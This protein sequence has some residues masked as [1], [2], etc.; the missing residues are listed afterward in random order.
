MLQISYFFW[1]TQC[2]W[3]TPW[4]KNKNSKIQASVTAGLPLTFSH[5]H[6]LF[7]WTVRTSSCCLFT[8]GAFLRDSILN[9]CCT[10]TNDFVSVNHKTHCT[11]M[12]FLNI[13][14][15]VQMRQWVRQAMRH[16]D[17]EWALDW[18]IQC[19]KNYLN[20]GIQCWH[21]QCFTLHDSFIIDI[22]HCT[23]L[24]RKPCTTFT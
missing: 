18:D 17:I 4:R 3:C 9:L 13:I 20:D 6:S 10:L 7:L 12:L 8:C 16:C 23:I 5:K 14:N 15:S 22:Q 11:F 2:S 21:F 1:C 19:V 24:L